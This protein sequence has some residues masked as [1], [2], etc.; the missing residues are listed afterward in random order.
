MT[1]P[2]TTIRALLMSVGAAAFAA[3]CQAPGGFD[4]LL[5]QFRQDAAARGTSGRGKARA[6]QQ[7]RPRQ[8]IFLP[9][10]LCIT[11]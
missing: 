4:T 9:S 1:P 3:Q 8:S 10:N 11:R 7:H 5:A 6:A 2:T